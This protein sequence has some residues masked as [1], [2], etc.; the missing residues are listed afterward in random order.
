MR[1]AG[2]FPDQQQL[3]SVVDSLKNLGLNR[4][5]MIISDLAQESMT[6]EQRLKDEI[7][8][9][10]ERDSIR[11]G[12]NGSFAEEFAGLNYR[13]GILVAVEMPAHISHRVREVME[14]SGALK[15]VQ[16]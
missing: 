1:I 5:D 7:M 11:Q 6:N 2:I 13:Q 3:G 14:Q 16:D 8:V 4:K 15:I 12:E 9:Q 10:S